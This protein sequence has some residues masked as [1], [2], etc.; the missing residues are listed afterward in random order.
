MKRR[1]LILREAR[2]PLLEDIL[3]K[4]QKSVVP[5]T[6]DLDHEQRTLLISGPNTGGKTVTLK[7]AGLLALMA[8]AG[9]PVPAAEAEFPLFDEVLADIGDH[10]SIQESLSTFSAHIVSIRSMLERATPD[11]LVLID[12]LGRATDPE[13]GGALGVAVLDAF[14]VRGAFTVAS[15]HLL[16]LKLYGASTAGV[17]NGSMGFDDATLEPTYV[18]R[19]GAPGKSAGL[20]IASRLGLDPALIQDARARMTTTERDIA[21]FLNEM[22]QRLDALDTE[23]RAVAEQERTLA[24]PRAVSR[25]NLGEEIRRQDS[26]AGTAR[27]RSLRAIRKASA[28]NHRRSQP[29]SPRQ[30]RQNPPRISGGR[31]IRHRRIRRRRS[32]AATAET[33]SKAPA[34]AS[35]TSASPPPSAAFSPTAF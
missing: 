22:H 14:R 31:R 5:I 2:H 24:A 1:R 4:Q 18:L 26:R 12:E 8:H 6:F 20:D 27:L 34:S 19:L 13:E 28:G 16:A 33:S 23:Q 17:R 29:K 7:T 35:R 32:R 21:H 15:T 10:Q 3:R 30:N 9:L 11:S 25:T